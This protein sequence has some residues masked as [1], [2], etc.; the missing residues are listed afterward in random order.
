LFLQTRRRRS[1]VLA[2]ALEKI[3]GRAA[4]LAGEVE[5]DAGSGLGLRFDARVTDGFREDEGGSVEG[6]VTVPD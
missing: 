2:E 6:Q 4:L 5:S 3:F 1:Q